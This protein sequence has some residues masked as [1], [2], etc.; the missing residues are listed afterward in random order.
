MSL[1]INDQDE[2]GKTALHWAVTQENI[3]F[4]RILLADDRTNCQPRDKDGR[5]PLHDAAIRGWEEGISTLL[6]RYGVDDTTSEHTDQDGR[7]PLHDAAIR[8]WEDGTS[9]PLPRY[10]TT[11]KH[12]GVRIEDNGG[13]TALHWYVEYGYCEAETIEGLARQAA[14]KATDKPDQ[15]TALHRAAQRGHKKA[16]EILLAIFARN[17]E[18]EP[19]NKDGKNPFYVAAENGQE[20]IAWLCFE[21][22]KLKPQHESIALLLIQ[23]CRDLNKDEFLLWATKEGYIK[24]VQLLRERGA[25]F[26]IIDRSHRTPLSYAAEKGHTIIVQLLLEGGADIDVDNRY[27]STP[28][29]FAVKN[30][31]EAT[32][33]LLLKRGADF[34]ITD[35]SFR[36]PLSYAAE[37]GQKVIV[38]LLL[39]GGADI[40]V[41]DLDSQTPLLFAAKNGQEATVQLLLERGADFTIND[42]SQRTP[43]SYA[44]ENGHKAIVQ[45]L[46]SYATKASTTTITASPSTGL[47]GGF[48]HKEQLYKSCTP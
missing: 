10:D 38:Q 4:V 3:D 45:L 37:N 44:A 31:Q 5:T 8:G 41:D 47:V 12:T 27:H 33:Q 2:F 1:D 9:T 46:E 24:V 18:P 43:L 42:D 35:R 40:N 39:E 17:Q 26:T 11:P 19:K 20:E 29:L 34:T 13:R 25:D 7:T 30:G 14:W 22:P 48:T 28:L 16:V 21:E 36:T 6:P 32:V 15:N 23:N